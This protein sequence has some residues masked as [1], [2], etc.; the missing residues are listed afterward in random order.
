MVV[1]R[2]AREYG[3]AMAAEAG[4]SVDAIREKQAA[5]SRQYDGAA[6]ADRALATALADVHA[7]TLV[8][9]RRLDA[10][11]AEIDRAVE[12]QTALG[13]DTPLGAHEFQ[14]FLLAKQREILAVVSDAHE[15]DRAKRVEL[16]KLTRQYAGSP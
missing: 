16:E 1:E 4:L 2:P 8:S 13:L 3:L 15:L 12:K 11:A 7:A 10:I 6:D 14:K 9:V 5:L